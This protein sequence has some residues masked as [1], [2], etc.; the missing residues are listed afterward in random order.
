MNFFVLIISIASLLL[1]AD[2]AASPQPTK[3]IRTSMPAWVVSGLG[4][5]VVQFWLINAKKEVSYVHAGRTA[6]SQSIIEAL[7][8]SPEQLRNA[9]AQSFDALQKVSPELA[10]LIESGLTTEDSY[11]LLNITPELSMFKSPTD[12]EN[13]CPP[14]REQK[15]SLESLQSAHPDGKFTLIHVEL[16]M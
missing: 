15:N 8:Q 14:C 10:Q 12:P 1:T 5:S 11:V 4:D 7:K 2:A 6:V 9:P 3:S 16:G 13:P